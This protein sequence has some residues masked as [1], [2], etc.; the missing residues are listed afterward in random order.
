MRSLNNLFC[1]NSRP[2]ESKM[3]AAAILKIIFL[4]INWSLLHIYTEFDTKGE[5]GF[6]ARVRFGIKFQLLHESKMAAAAIL[7]SVK[8]R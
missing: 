4:A 1:Q 2:S 6:P 7:K 8:R 5:N 3:A